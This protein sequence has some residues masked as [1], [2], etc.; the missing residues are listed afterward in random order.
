MAKKINSKRTVVEVTPTDNPTALVEARY[1]KT[2]HKKWHWVGE[3]CYDPDRFTVKSIKNCI[4]ALD[5]I[6]ATGGRNDF[7]AKDLGVPVQTLTMLAQNGGKISLLSM[8]DDYIKTSKTY[9]NVND[10]NDLIT[11]TRTTKVR[12]FSIAHPFT[13]EDVKEMRKGLIQR[14]FTI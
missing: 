14:F 4:K 6:I 3:D 10:P 12:L 5:K 7:T 9:V 13:I 1:P 11:L 2:C 8:R